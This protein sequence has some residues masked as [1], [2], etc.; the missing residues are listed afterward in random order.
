[1]SKIA[2]TSA[3]SS[4][5]TVPNVVKA[6]PTLGRPTKQP[7]GDSLGIQAAEITLDILSTITSNGAAIGLSDIARRTG[8]I[9]SKAHRYLV[10]LVQ[11]GMLRQS[12]ANGLYDLGPAAVEIGMSALNRFDPLAIIQ[13]IVPVLA[14]KTGFTTALYVWTHLGPTL[15]RV[16]S[17]LHSLPVRLK[18]G[19]AVP[20][21]GSATGRVFLAY[22]SRQDTEALVANERE[23]AAADELAFPTEKQIEEI[24]SGVRSEAVYWTRDAI[25]PGAAAVLPLFSREGE[26]VAA[27]MQ[28]MPPGKTGAAAKSAVISALTEAMETLVSKSGFARRPVS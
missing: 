10:S 7:H 19:T 3:T 17:G 25:V 12:A 2:K 18:V 15:I 23:S 8:L 27:I 26:L 21:V 5:P 14:A 13:E 24:V 6:K 4:G 20:M 16:E 9:P 22:L 28:G 11:R 1:M